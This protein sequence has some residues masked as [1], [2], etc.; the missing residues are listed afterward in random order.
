MQVSITVD[1]CYLS[2]PTSTG[3]N[4]SK[5]ELLF[6]MSYILLAQE[7]QVE[8]IGVLLG[9]RASTQ[10]MGICCPQSQASKT[11]QSASKS[12]IHLPSW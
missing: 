4:L 11:P 12:M 3:K 5:D 2:S 6:L 9:Q 10:A 7:S 8:D 1:T